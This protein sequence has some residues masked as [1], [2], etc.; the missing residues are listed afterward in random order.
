MWIIGC[1]G[2]RI[3]ADEEPPTRAETDVEEETDSS[4]RRDLSNIP[5]E[6]LTRREI[7]QEIDRL[8]AKFRPSR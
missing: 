8:L 2:R 5:V 4:C 1:N 6:K 7:D 3:W